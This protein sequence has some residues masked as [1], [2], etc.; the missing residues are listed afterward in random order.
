[1]KFLKDENVVKNIITYSF[2]GI[3]IMLFYFLISDI[4][5]LVEFFKELVLILRPFIIGGVI[6]YLLRTPMNI[7]EYKFLINLKLRDKPRHYIAVLLSLIFGLL[8]ILVFIY[9]LVP[10]LFE[11]I[12]VL[13]ANL[14]AYIRNL[15]GVIIDLCAQ[16]NIDVSELLDVLVSKIPST[17]ELTSIAMNF[18]TT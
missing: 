17:Q 15:E 8:C 2:A 10:Q 9:I 12:L 18:M 13:F 16:F 6:A 3:M 5:I 11:S 14:E 1:M 4:K 7:I